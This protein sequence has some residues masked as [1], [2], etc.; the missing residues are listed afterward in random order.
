MALKHGRQS[1]SGVSLQLVYLAE[2][3]VLR[4]WLAEGGTQHLHTHFGTNS[5]TVALL[6]RLLGG[7]TFSFTSHGPEE[8]DRPRAIG[9]DDKVR[10]CA[11]VVGISQFGASQLYRWS[12][13][14]DWSKVEVVRC[15]VDAMFLSTRPTPIP[16]ASHFVNVARLGREK[17]QVIAV[18]AMKKL[19]DD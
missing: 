1:G 16:D 10:H 4:K 2:A 11:F 17:G 7:P 6:C 14:E 15:G 5:A 9:L 12:D 3:C 18:R 8:Y 13:F 19:V